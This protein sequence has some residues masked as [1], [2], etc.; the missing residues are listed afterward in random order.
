[1]DLL[2]N[3]G[4]TALGVMGASKLKGQRGKKT[5]GREK[6]LVETIDR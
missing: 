6:K 5:I 2:C 4:G 3:T 1:M